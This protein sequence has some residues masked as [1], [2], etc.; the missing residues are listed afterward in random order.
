[1]YPGVVSTL[2]TRQR[3]TA[4]CCITNK[5]GAPAQPLMQAAGLRPI[6]RSL[7]TAA[8]G[9]KPSPA[10]LPRARAWGDAA[11]DALRRDSAT[12]MEAAHAAGCGAIAVSYGYDER[13]RYGAGNPDAVIASFSELDRLPAWAP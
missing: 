10:L 3:R 7:G 4:L 6:C 5:D 8:A 13:I 9:R 2:S 1:V 12:D 11:A